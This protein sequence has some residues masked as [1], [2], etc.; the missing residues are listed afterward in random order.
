MLALKCGLDLSPSST[1]RN[2][3]SKRSLSVDTKIAVEDFYSNDDISWQAPGKKDRMIIRENSTE[4]KVLKRTIQLR[5]MLMSLRE[6]YS[7]FQKSHP[8]ITIGLSKFSEFRPKHIKLFDKIPHNVC[9]CSYH[10][11]IRLLLLALKSSTKLPTEF[12]DFVN[13]VVC[14]SSSKECMSNQCSSCRNKI[15]NFKPDSDLENQPIKYMQWQKADNK[16]DKVEILS[17]VKET[18]DELV[19]QLKPFLIHTF[20]KRNQSKVFEDLK[21]KVDRK[22][23]VIQLDFSEN[24]TLIHKNE[25][26]SAHWTH[27]QATVFTVHAWIDEKLSQSIVVVSDNLDHTKL[28]IYK[29][30][31]YVF[32]WLKDKY[33]EIECINVFSD[34]PSSQ[35][36]QRY[37]FSNLFLFETS[38]EIKLTWN[39][40]ASSHGKGVVDGIGGT[41][42]RTVWRHVKAGKVLVNTAQQFAVVAA[43]MNPSVHI[44]FLSNEEIEKNSESLYTKWEVALPVPNIQSVH[45]VKPSSYNHVQISDISRDP[46]IKIVPI[47]PISEESDLEASDIDDESNNLPPVSIC[48]NDWILVKYDDNVY[49]GYATQ[50][51]D[52]EI[53]V[54]VMHRSEGSFKWPYPED[55][56]FYKLDNVVKFIK[57]PIP[58]GNRGQFTFMEHF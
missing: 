5:Y 26:Q 32:S 30:V 4:G 17:T 49:P 3:K 8:T 27:S 1:A 2:D 34:G 13:V 53:E 11:N 12:S 57:P 55:K 56:I 10:E 47:F 37:L 6:A 25:I 16:T 14:E 54:T 52:K 45:C 36:K 21:S 18:F 20:I 44:K 41:V 46:Q 40:F 28:S 29:F 43:E 39:F 24:A 19:N 22:N 42:K 23:I 7:Q 51:T 9:V 48:V 15:F 50:V 38:H 35:F 33:S 58:T 31:D